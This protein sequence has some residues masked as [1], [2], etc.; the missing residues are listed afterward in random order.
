MIQLGS[1]KL[2]GVTMLMAVALHGQEPICAVF[3]DLKAADG[4]QLFVSG[5]LIISKDFAAIGAADCDNRYISDR[6]RWPTALRLRSSAKVPSDQIR[7]LRDAATE[8]DGLRRDGKALSASASFTGRVHL[9]EAEGLPGEFTFDSLDDVK[10][11]AL[12]DAGELPVIP[13]CELFQSLTTWKGQRIAVRGEVVG[14]ME[15]S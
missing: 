10:I 3:K 8:A 2:L 13:I 11:E 5:E 7:R 4:R 6:Y 15:G 14:T 1:A 12:P 9:G